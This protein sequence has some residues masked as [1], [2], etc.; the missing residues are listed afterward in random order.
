MTP[1]SKLKNKSSRARETTPRERRKR[2][3]SQPPLTTTSTTT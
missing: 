3:F 1:N 2:D